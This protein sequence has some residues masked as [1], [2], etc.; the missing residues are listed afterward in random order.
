MSILKQSSCFI[1]DTLSLKLTVDVFQRSNTNKSSNTMARDLTN[2]AT[3]HYI[4]KGTFA[5]AVK[6]VGPYP[7]RLLDSSY[8]ILNM[9][10]NQARRI[11]GS[12]GLPEY[13]RVDIEY[14]Y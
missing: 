11:E 2:D 12:G 9:Y 5:F 13:N 7:E 10:M 6:L 8:F 14:D 1:G 4:G 3:K